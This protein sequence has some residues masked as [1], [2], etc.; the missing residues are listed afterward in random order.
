MRRRTP[1]WILIPPAISLIYA[2]AVVVAAWTAPEKGFQA[3]VG[4]HVAIVDDGGPA[5]VAGLR[6]GDLIVTADG[7]PITSTLDYAFRVLRREPQELVTLGVRRDGADLAIPIR[8]GESPPPWS[9]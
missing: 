2:I 8:F 4:Q 6:A 1:P 5:E 9:A 3:F 7:V